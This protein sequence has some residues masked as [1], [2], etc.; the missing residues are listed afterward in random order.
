M[1]HDISAFRRFIRTVIPPRLRLQIQAFIKIIRLNVCNDILKKI[2]GNTY[3]EIGIDKGY[4][5][6]AIRA[7]HKIGI[8]PVPEPKIVK[9]D[10]SVR[11]FSMESDVFFKNHADNVFIENG[12]D[13]AL[14]DG[15]HEYNQVLRDIENCLKYLND[16]GVIIVHD[17]NPA[18]EPQG[19]STYLEARELAEKSG[20]IL[21]VW[22]GDVWK[23]ITHIRATRSDLEAFVL[24]CDYGLGVVRK[25]LTESQLIDLPKPVELLNYKDLEANREKFLGLRAPQEVKY[26]IESL[27][28]ISATKKHQTEPSNNMT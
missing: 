22:N 3:L 23:A 24:D 9:Q 2:N 16:S 4:I 20:V 21:H 17:C 7:E 11:Y 28:P 19:C 13:V 15:L 6:T 12:V 14:V 27:N 18:I 8:D 1:K 26:F 5:L 10:P 25:A